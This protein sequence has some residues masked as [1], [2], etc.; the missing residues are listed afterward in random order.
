[1]FQTRLTFILLWIAKDSFLKNILIYILSNQAL[2]WPKS[3]KKMGLEQHKVEKNMT[4][5]SFFGELFV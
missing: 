1:M 4:E 5:H 2:K 3:T